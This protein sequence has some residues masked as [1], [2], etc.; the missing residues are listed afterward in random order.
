MKEPIVST[1]KSDPVEAFLG[2]MD[3][4]VLVVDETNT[5]CYA[6]QAMSRLLA[7]PVDELVGKPPGFQVPETCAGEIT[8]PT[9]VPLELCISS[10]P[11]R[12]R[13]ARL[14][15]F[16]DISKHKEAEAA[17]R[18][19]ESRYRL[20]AQNIPNSG[21]YVFDRELRF[22]TAEDP[23]LAEHGFERADFEGTTLREV[24]D[25]DTARVLEPLY[26]RT[27][28]GEAGETEIQRG[29]IRFRITTTP[30]RDEEGKVYAG[31]AM[32]Q[33]ITRIKR[34]E[35][36]IR[37]LNEQLQDMLRRE[38]LAREEA[39][40]QRALLG[41][42][43]DQA[44][45]MMC[46]VEGPQQVFLYANEIYCRG[47][48]RTK[49]ELL[50]KPVFEVL[51]E[52]MQ[53]GL[54]EVTEQVFR[55]GQPFHATERLVPFD[56]DQDGT[57][58]DMYFTFSYQP[59]RN[60]DGQVTGIVVHAIDVTESVEA[61][62]ILEQKSQEIAALNRDLEQRVAERT[63]ELAAA[64]QEL[65]A[66]AYSVSHDLRAP[67]RR[68]DG[69]SRV[70]LE[71]WGHKLDDTGWHHLSRIR[72]G[73]QHMGELIDDMLTLAQVSRQT[74][75]TE[76]VDLSDLAHAAVSNLR[77]QAPEREV[78]VHIEP[79]MS[80]R[81]DARFLRV[82]LDNLLDNAWKFT[83]KQDQAVVEIGEAKAKA[84]DGERVFFVRDNGA[85]FDPAFK[86]KLF[87][88]FNRLHSPADF[89]GTGIG[90]AT[91]KRV[92]DRHG[93]RIWAEGAV[94]EGAVF[95]VALPAR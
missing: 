89:P 27:I 94:N 65:E 28:A 48:G 23:T 78:T 92:L 73:T 64:N 56:I 43:V 67:L 66:F 9:G 17:L 12:D 24:I 84:R 40:N 76:E 91:V 21:L 52:L 42:I 46:V 69:F 45:S 62:R 31:M 14:F 59:M 39:E 57:L 79:A 68:I 63:A 53:T 32:S 88:A 36:E 7:V 38:Q 35:Q 26:T 8:S 15:T 10:V 22:I 60:T 18:L 80:A 11:W 75:E 95:Y 70:L 37:E 47:I 2:A 71:D 61:R 90:L 34:I 72:V 5:V 87:S 30:I 74:L 13:P 44:P 51:P 29:D 58:H 41:E 25:E 20:L 50:G 4:G 83:G 49:A 33:N 16:R 82:V 85:G 81:G 77:E 93:G 86:G 1:Q 55:T 3:E 19:S 54:H 6:N